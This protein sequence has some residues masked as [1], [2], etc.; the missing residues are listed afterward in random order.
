MVRF[1][2]N[3]P[4]QGEIK[5]AI[6]Y[7]IKDEFTSNTAFVVCIIA[8]ANQKG[9]SNS[10]VSDLD[11]RADGNGNQRPR[12]KVYDINHE[13]YT[14]ILTQFREM[15]AQ[16]AEQLQLHDDAQYFFLPLTCYSQQVQN[17]VQNEGHLFYWIRLPAI[18][19]DAEGFYISNT[20]GKYLA[21]KKPFHVLGFLSMGA[22]VSY[23]MEQSKK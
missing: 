7:V 16:R 14:S 3:G 1:Q 11:V 8:H 20:G 17:Q 4:N 13:T 23:L 19:G 2:Q 18:L 5:R 10:S 22:I 6:E 9:E 12:E 21:D 15:A